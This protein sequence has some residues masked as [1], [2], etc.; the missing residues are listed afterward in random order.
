MKNRH[1]LQTRFQE[2]KIKINSFFRQV[3]MG[4]KKAR[5]IVSILLS[6]V[7]LSVF[8]CS[9]SAWNPDGVTAELKAAYAA[10][11][12][13]VDLLAIQKTMHV[14]CFEN[15]KWSF[16]NR[17]FSA[18]F[19]SQQIDKLS[20][21]GKIYP[22]RKSDLSFGDTTGY[23]EKSNLF[24]RFIGVAPD[25]AEE[26]FCLT[27]VAQSS[28][29]PIAKEE[30][31]ITD[32]HADL[33]MRYGYSDVQG[34]NK[35]QEISSPDE[36]LGKRIAGMTIVGVYAT[37]PSYGELKKKGDAFLESYLKGESMINT[38]F[39]SQEYFE[40]FY[41]NRIVYRLSGS[42]AKDKKRIRDISFVEYR[43]FT[44][45]H[46]K[47]S[48]SR[49]YYTVEVK[50]S[51]SEFAAPAWMFFHKTFLTVTLTAS[52][53]LSALS[54][55]LLAGVLSASN[56][57]RKREEGKKRLIRLCFAESATVAGF[58]FL[59]SSAFG[60]LICLILNRY[61]HIFWFGLNAISVLCLALF[62]FGLA[63]VAAIPTVKRIKK[64]EQR[65][66]LA[67]S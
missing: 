53:A 51:Y 13:T 46:D 11:E 55:V 47:F 66:E 29:L 3:F 18:G 27:P 52:V 60:G 41:L 15:G 22:A 63:A 10:G 61:Y 2:I 64:T 19:T 4:A 24:G 50:S 30:V 5:L 45:A 23:T 1:K 8:A 67:Q 7:S 28:R 34:D 17:T 42:I 37:Q 59:L 49:N 62:C 38:G 20:L 26:E 40:D 36:L 9:L 48:Y 65:E 25:T 58:E 12:K 35:K 44:G 21:E 16:W 6:V 57:T 32:Y 14:A 56:E 54:T 39:I 31:A 33:F 43:D